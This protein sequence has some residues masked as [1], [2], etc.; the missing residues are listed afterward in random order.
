MS[1]AY[2]LAQPDT[3]RS[4]PFGKLDKTPVALTEK[5]R[6]KDLASVVGQG[7]IV[8]QLAEFADAP[9]SAVF[10]FEG[11]TGVGKTTTALALAAELGAVEYGGLHQIKSGTQDAEAVEQILDS[12]RFTPMLGSGWKVVIVD[13][14]DYMSPKASQLWLSALEDLP[15]YSVVIFTTNHPEKFTPRF[16]D[17][18]ERFK[19]Q[20]DPGLL[21]QDAQALANAIWADE[22]GR[23]DAPNVAGLDIVAGDAISFRR[24]VRALEPLI[25]QAKATQET[26]EPEVTEG[27][28][29]F[30]TD[31]ADSPEPMEPM[32]PMS[33][34]PVPAPIPSGVSWHPPAVEIIGDIVPPEPAGESPKDACDRYRAEWHKDH[35]R[36]PKGP[37]IPVEPVA[38]VQPAPEPDSTPAPKGKTRMR[39]G[40]V[41]RTKLANGRLTR[42]DLA[43]GLFVHYST[44]AAH[45]TLGKPYGVFVPGAGPNGSTLTIGATDTLSAALG[46]AEQWDAPEVQPAPDNATVATLAASNRILSLPSPRP[47]LALPAPKVP[48][49]CCSPSESAPCAAC[50][51]SPLHGDVELGGPEV[52]ESH[53][54][55]SRIFA[56]VP[57]PVSAA[58][59]LTIGE[60]SYGL[61]ILTAPDGSPVYRLDYRDKVYDVTPTGDIHGPACTCPDF[62]FNRAGLDAAGCKHIKALRSVGLLAPVPAPP[63]NGPDSPEGE[64]LTPAPLSPVLSLA[65][66]GF[67]VCGGSP[68]ADDPRLEVLGDAAQDEAEA[69]AARMLAENG[70]D[71][72]EWAE[73]WI[74]EGDGSDLDSPDTAPIIGGTDGRDF[75]CRACLRLD[76]FP[77]H[78][79][80]DTDCHPPTCKECGAVMVPE[81]TFA[82][83]PLLYAILRADLPPARNPDL[84]KERRTVWAKAIRRLLRD[85]GIKGVS[86]TT[87]HYSMAHSIDV[88]LP[89]GTPHDRGAADHEYRD[90]P[91]CQE[92]NRARDRITRIILA[93]FPDLDNR[94][95]LQSDYYDFCLSV[96]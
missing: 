16:L 23:S 63:S 51:T 19:F 28:G 67:P 21:R 92:R 48:A 56:N 61:A 55:P 2:R 84:R 62:V 70:D 68:E 42:Y 88:K 73:C 58:L 50:L 86:I 44:A 69:V 96:D 46:L 93:A 5:H 13:E 74:D 57:A 1:L 37:E 41:S 17:R 18:C 83:D 27:S 52:F 94:S 40:V 49:P 85:L 33:P 90:C 78:G 66:A 79:D 7:A 4:L 81:G 89:A 34:A 32:E 47:M 72:T 24:V 53:P 45:R 95:D 43:S 82:P 3:T 6:P 59:S 29:V 10:L 91:M 60:K 75:R 25:R 26:A 39:K 8:F 11:P 77:V 64:P 36:A 71:S 14:A 22:T 20:S 15:P 38:E 31:S 80:T 65:L 54:L 35:P 9:H 87:P 76:D 30:G 12:L